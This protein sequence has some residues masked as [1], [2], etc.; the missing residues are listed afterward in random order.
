[1][2]SP[3][4]RGR[5]SLCFTEISRTQKCFRIGT[6]R[7]VSMSGILICTITKTTIELPT[8]F[9]SI[10]P[11]DKVLDILYQTI[12]EMPLNTS[13]KLPLFVFVGVITQKVFYL[14]FF[15]TCFELVL[16]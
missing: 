10:M 11:W 15:Q 9:K 1:M 3:T 5:H 14:G 16:E 8:S 13:E 7:D 6:G 4:Q 12:I 2:S